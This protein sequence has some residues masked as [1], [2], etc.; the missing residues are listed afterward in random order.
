MKI[1]KS[2]KASSHARLVIKFTGWLLRMCF[3]D[4]KKAEKGAPL[5]GFEGVDDVYS[6]LPAVTVTGVA[7][8]NP[9]RWPRFGGEHPVRATVHKYRKA[10]L[11]V[12]HGDTEQTLYKHLPKTESP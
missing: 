7:L 6:P 2:T 8:S 3:G 9:S 10:G 5:E 11:L 1:S 12:T 4:L